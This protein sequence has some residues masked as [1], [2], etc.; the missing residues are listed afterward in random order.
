M[1]VLPVF[2]LVMGL[3]QVEAKVPQIER[4]GESSANTDPRAGYGAGCGSQDVGLGPGWRRF[5]GPTVGG[6]EQTPE[7]WGVSVPRG[8]EGEMPC[9]CRGRSV[10]VKGVGVLSVGLCPCCVLSV[11]ACG[12]LR[13]KDKAGVGCGCGRMGPPEEGER[14]GCSPDRSSCCNILFPFLCSLRPIEVSPL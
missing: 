2:L 7:S 11:S 4:Q 6:R 14:G 10:P 13:R 12:E 9:A 1:T 3:L 5:C 8:A